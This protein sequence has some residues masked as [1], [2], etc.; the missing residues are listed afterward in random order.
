M[1]YISQHET[2]HRSAA[3]AVAL[4]P[5][6]SNNLTFSLEEATSRLSLLV[7]GAKDQENQIFGSNFDHETESD[8]E[9]ELNGLAEDGM[10]SFTID[11]LTD[12]FSSNEIKAKQQQQSLPDGQFPG[13]VRSNC[14][15]PSNSTGQF[16]AHAQEKLG[17]PLPRC[18]NSGDLLDIGKTEYMLVSRDDCVNSI[19]RRVTLIFLRGLQRSRDW[20]KML[21][22]LK[23]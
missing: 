13:N 8:K 17:K 22:R 4:P 9:E 6:I 18:L 21:R 15:L 10:N 7:E 1:T 2:S 5:A 19:Y 3:G 16:S 11:D 12:D 14:V 20:F 23:D